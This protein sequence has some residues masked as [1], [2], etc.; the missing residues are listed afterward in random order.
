MA[1]HVATY[2][3]ESAKQSE[4]IGASP[5]FRLHN[6]TILTLVDHSPEQEY[7]LLLWFCE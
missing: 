7:V 5:S 6:I 4:P 2:G 3:N 1:A